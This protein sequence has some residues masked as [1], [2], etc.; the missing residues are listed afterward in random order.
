MSLIAVG[1]I[2][3]DNLKTPSG[4]RTD[5]LGGSA[6]HFAMSAGYF[7]DVHLV[8]VVGRDFPSR[9]L[10]FF[11]RRGVDVSSVITGGDATFKWQG[12]Y[13]DGD[14][15]HAITLKTELGVL[16]NYEP[17]IAEKQ[18]SIP[19]VFLANFSPDVQMKFL[20]LMKSSK[21]V[22]LDSMNLWINIALPDLK[23]LM[24]KVDLFVANEGEAAALTGEKNLV[25]AA[26]A[27]RKMGPPIVV[28]KKGEHGVI[29]AGPNFLFGFPAYPVDKVVDPTGAG[30]TF[31]GGLM[32]YLAKAGKVNETTL[33]RACV[34]ATV[35][36]SF[37]VEG[38]GVARTAALK[39]EDINRRLKAYRNFSN[40]TI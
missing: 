37:N 39:T 24:K 23:A 6:S 20:R 36:G 10:T 7:T 12:E 17:R 9:H 13:Q 4:E 14:F 5:L 19:N 40:T 22:G 28:V 16:Q 11:K 3:L 35:W 30:D 32:G 1:T 27:L 34:Y 31:A 25:R 15:S 18:R 33:R 2:A 26:A 29:V 8:S 38:F 21:F